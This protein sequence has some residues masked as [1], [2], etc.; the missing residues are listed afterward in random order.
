MAIEI[1]GIKLVK[2]RTGAK[3]Q[4][5]KVFHCPG[6]GPAIKAKKEDYQADEDVT[7]KLV[8]WKEQEGLVC[9]QVPCGNGP[10]KSGVMYRSEW[11]KANECMW[12]RKAIYSE[13][14]PDDVKKAMSKG[15]QDGKGSKTSKVSET[16]D[17]EIFDT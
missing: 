2:N 16:K 15:G 1:E 11:V 14:I 6:Q 7:G 5:K 4:G 3:L 17:P 9:L 10:G 8:D 12:G 13:S